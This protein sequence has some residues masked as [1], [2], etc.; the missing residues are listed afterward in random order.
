MNITSSV[1]AFGLSAKLINAFVASSERGGAEHLSKESDR[2]EPPHLRL[3]VTLRICLREQL[4]LERYRPASAHMFLYVFSSNDKRERLNYASPHFKGGLGSLKK[5]SLGGEDCHEGNAG[6]GLGGLGHKQIGRGGL[7]SN[8]G[9]EEGHD[10]GSGGNGAAKAKRIRAV[11]LRTV[12]E[13]VKKESKVVLT[14][15]R[16]KKR[17][18]EASEVAIERVDWWENNTEVVWKKF[19][20]MKDKETKENDVKKT[21]ADG[22]SSEEDNLQKKKTEKTASKTEKKKTTTESK[23]FQMGGKTLFGTKTVKK[24]DDKTYKTD[25]KTQQYNRQVK[26]NK[27]ANGTVTD[28][29]DESYKEDEKKS[30][31]DQ[32]DEKETKYI[33]VLGHDIKVGQKEKKTVKRKDEES[34]QARTK[35]STTTISK[36]KEET[37]EEESAE[38]SEKVKESESTQ[39]K[40]MEKSAPSDNLSEDAPCDVL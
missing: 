33:E 27:S 15:K 30:E 22:S 34:Q 6:V 13:S 35:K 32:K 37:D 20:G 14:E 11:P 17:V 4:A 23:G 5:H 8:D 2:P 29:D 39:T 24:E 18:R 1:F 10:G 21:N 25:S 9:C 28:S 16:K 40:S 3:L 36:D 7:G 38:K 12:R 31:L 26:K 19:G